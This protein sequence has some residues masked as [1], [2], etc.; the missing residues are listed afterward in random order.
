MGLLFPTWD[1]GGAQS[2][3]VSRVAKFQIFKDRAGE[4][5]WRLR[6]DN[7]ETIADSSDGY[8]SKASCKNGI[9]LVKKLAS[10]A[11]VEDLTD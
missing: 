8:K 3:E 2:K 1:C 5:W 9:A 11:R 10:A 6:A 7:Y 4:Y